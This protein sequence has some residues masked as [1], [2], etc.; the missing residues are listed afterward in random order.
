[1]EKGKVLTNAAFDNA[2]LDF[3]LKNMNVIKDNKSKNLLKVYGVEELPTTFLINADG[4]IHQRWDSI[5]LPA[6]LAFSIE[7]ILGESHLKK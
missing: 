6:P 2:I 1:M 5:A 3:E 4:T 7:S